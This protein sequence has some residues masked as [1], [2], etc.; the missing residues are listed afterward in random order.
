MKHKPKHNLWVNKTLVYKPKPAVQ[1][2]TTTAHK[3]NNNSIAT[4]NHKMDHTACLWCAWGILGMPFGDPWGALGVPFGVPGRPLGDLWSHFGRPKG[5]HRT[6][7]KNGT[8]TK[9]NTPPLGHF[10]LQNG[11]PGCQNVVNKLYFFV[12][13]CTSKFKYFLGTYFSRKSDDF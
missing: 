8:G 13:K 9:K 5:D 1:K 6:W 10:W 7:A 11:S 2:P 12:L 3:P 4:R